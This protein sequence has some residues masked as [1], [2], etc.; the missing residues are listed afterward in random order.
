MDRIDY[1]K[2][3]GWKKS[4]FIKSTSLDI[5]IIARVDEYDEVC[6]SIGGWDRIMVIT[7]PIGYGKTTFM[8]QLIMEKPREVKYVIS[9]NAYEPI[10]GVMA[11]IISTLPFWKRNFKN[12]DKTGFGEELQK[13]L[14]NNKMLLIFDEAQD[15]HNDLLKWLRILNDR[16]ET[17]FMIFIGLSGL[18]DKI[19]SEASFRDRKSKSLHLSTFN[20]EDLEELIVQRIKWAGGKKTHPFTEDGIK[21]LAESANNVPRLLLDNGQKVIEDGAKEEEFDISGDYVEKVLGRLGRDE[22]QMI[23]EER[24]TLNNVRE[25]VLDDVSIE[26]DTSA[27]EN[28]NFIFELSPTQQDIVKL[29]LKH[30]SLSISEF[31][32]MLSK[33]I[34]SLG[35][36]IRKLR[37]L[38]P[39]EVA[40]KPNVPYPI[41]V[42]KG[43]ENR[44][45]RIQYI[46]T[47]SDR[48]R[49]LLTWE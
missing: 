2:R 43:K 38:N 42:R 4:P 10:E 34:R 29:L 40:R 13:K 22:Q 47:L 32:Q 35:S 17:L 15:Y 49:R 20:T 37:G 25:D 11:R 44:M 19:T 9:F 12:V 21:R 7:A 14:G 8:N 30:E 36:L 33:D 3:L 26:A 45:G 39:S 23:V 24:T 41:I 16:C 28:S 6:E 46:Y 1:Y 27:A 18:E 31:S 5:P 48:A